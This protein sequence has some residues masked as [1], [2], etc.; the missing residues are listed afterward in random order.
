MDINP[1][2]ISLPF[3]NNQKVEN[4]R[5]GSFSNLRPLAQDTVSFSGFF[6]KKNPYTPEELADFLCYFSLNGYNAVKDQIEDLNKEELKKFAD[7]IDQ[8][9]R[10]E[11]NAKIKELFF[12]LSPREVGYLANGIG[13]ICTKLPEE[14]K[15]L[16]YI[17]DVVN[18]TPEPP[19][20][21]TFKERNLD[22]LQQMID[23]V[24]ANYKE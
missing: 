7:H 21:G 14:K 1:I 17:K 3:S 4:H 18:K 8:N 24:E 15:I 2:K 13:Y 23:Y 16:H 6:G 10:E 11:D 22:A 9:L 19:D 20:I 5:N 12:H